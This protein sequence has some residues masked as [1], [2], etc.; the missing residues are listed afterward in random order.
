[1]DIHRPEVDIDRPQLY[2]FYLPVSIVSLIIYVQIIVEIYRKRASFIYDSLF[3]RM[4]CSQSIYDI[5]YVIMYFVMELPQDWKALTPFYEV[6][7]DTI[8][9]QLIYA[10]LFMCFIGQILGV[11]MMAISRMLLVCHP[12]RKITNQMKNLT[13]RHVILLHCLIPAL[14][15]WY[16]QKHELAF[17]IL[18]LATSF[19]GKAGATTVHGTAASFGGAI[20]SIVLVVLGLAGSISSAVCYVRISLT[21]RKRPFHVWRSELH[22]LASSF[23]LFCALCTLTAYFVVSLYTLYSNMSLYFPV[24]KH[25]YAFTFFLSLANPWCLIISSASMRS[26]VLRRTLPSCCA[27]LPLFQSHYSQSNTPIHG[28]ATVSTLWNPHVFTS[29][30]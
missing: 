7:N 14:Y 25:F 5:T 22:I 8:I 26:A 20:N 24:R 1:M 17:R 27:R 4:T 23:V 6:M 21:L 3:F 18:N 30:P 15:A 11:T 16:E 2:I 28:S 19:S 9:P 10:H 12:A 13:T 29:H